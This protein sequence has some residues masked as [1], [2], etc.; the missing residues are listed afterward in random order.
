[1]GCRQKFA[2]EGYKAYYST[3]SLVCRGREQG[4]KTGR[5][6]SRRFQGKTPEKRRLFRPAVYF[7]C[8]LTFRRV[9]REYHVYFGPFSHFAFHREGRAVV[10]SR[11]FDNRKPKPRAAD[12]LG[13]AFIH[14]VEPFE[15]PV[16]F[17]RRNTDPRVRHGQ[18][19]ALRLPGHRHGD[20]AAVPVIF[21]GVVAQ[22]KDHFL[23]YGRNPVNLGVVAST[24]QMKSLFLGSQS[25][26][27]QYRLG[28][29]E[30]IH[31][32]AFLGLAALVQLG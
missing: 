6:K 15:D 32:G 4:Q 17:R 5:E 16:L 8:L 3:A 22:V 27:I 21:D 1:M 7:A 18:A 12:L 13:M 23:Q 31:R 29:G 26:G 10:R 20:R 24:D 14:P 19:Y 30:Q 28:Q 11:V 2:N 9:L 25:Q